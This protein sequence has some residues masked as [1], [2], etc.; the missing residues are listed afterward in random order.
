MKSILKNIEEAIDGL[1]WSS[2]TKRDKALQVC[3]S[4]FDKYLYSPH[5]FNL[6]IQLSH[7][8]F[9]RVIRTK[10]YVYEIKNTLIEGGI[11]ECNNSYRV[12]TG[13][14]EGKAKG[15]RF[16]RKLINGDYNVT[17]CYPKP[18]QEVQPKEQHQ[19]KEVTFQLPTTY[20]YNYNYSTPG[21][22]ITYC[23]PNL[24]TLVTT[25]MEKM[26]FVPEVY[27]FLNIFQV[28]MDDVILNDD[29]TDE[30]LNVVFDDNDY[31]YSVTTA[32][33][34][35][36]QQNLDV[37]LYGGKCYFDNVH[38]F[39]YR[40]SNDLRII[41]K[42]YVFDIQNNILY[43]GRNDTNDRFDYNLTNMKSELLEFIRID[44]EKLIEI[45]I[46]NSQFAIFN[47]IVD[48]LDAQ[49]SEHASK[50]TLYTMVS[51]ER[52]FRVAFD[53]VRSEFDDVRE[54]FPRTMA[55]VDEFKHLNGYKSFSNLLQ[56]NESRIMI[57]YVMS[58]L[59]NEGYTVFPIHDAFRVK[60]SEVDMVQR[61]IN[62]L[63]DDIGFKCLLRKKKNTPKS[64][65]QQ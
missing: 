49:F 5:D 40:K 14:K 51:K 55:F 59:I 9:D 58:T 8:W 15:Y 24:E 61:R 41:Y 2:K 6:Y 12:G 25:G 32:L 43:T 7:K 56:K 64:S 1:N 44:G 20:N 36:R 30:Y 63:F 21:C 22:L 50:G 26:E 11:I 31:R 35:A 42:R 13:D 46:A 27:D 57:D 45:D 53:K 16:N 62:E 33:E 37:I 19:P 38:N 65:Q 4:L 17:L 48:G 52:M 60:E 54:V 39:L 47:Y 34:F 3:I 23:Y 10:N 29:I 18:E 28:N